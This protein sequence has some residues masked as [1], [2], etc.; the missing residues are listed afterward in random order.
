MKTTTLCLALALISAQAFA[1]TAKEIFEK[2]EAQKADALAAYLA[3][4]PKAT[5]ATDA[6]NLLVDAYTNAGN[7]DKAGGILE[8]RYSGMAKGADANLQELIA[9]VVQPLFKL[10]AGNGKKTEAKDLLERARKDLAAHP[11]ASQISQFFD[12][13]GG[14]LA[15]P[16][17]GDTLDIAFT[18]TDGTEVNLAKMKDKVVL[19]DFWATWCGPCVAELPNVL[20]AYKESHANGFEVIGISLDQDKGALDGFVKQR[21]MAWPQHF[22]GKGWESPLVQKFG[23]RSIPATFLIGKDGKVAAAD[24]RGEEL[25]IKVKELLA[26]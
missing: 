16:S 11:Q 19:V 20:A 25:A 18:A 4:N 8:K 2:F 17:V 6:E 10:Y 21:E 14:E 13:L 23:I 9:G 24:L 3:A 1:E 26:K 15:M 5:D 7:I 12:Q 22:D